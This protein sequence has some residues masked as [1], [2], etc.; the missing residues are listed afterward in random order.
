MEHRVHKPVPLGRVK[1]EGWSARS[2]RLHSAW[3]KGH[4]Y[5]LV[6][7]QA[8]VYHWPEYQLSLSTLGSDNNGNI[9]SS[10]K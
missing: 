2:P 6:I 9:N 8:K 10:Q 7:R 5:A 4:F 1:R 3:K